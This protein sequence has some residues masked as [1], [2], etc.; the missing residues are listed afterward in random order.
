MQL[1]LCKDNAN[2]RKESLLFIF[3]VRLILCKNN[4][5]GRK[6]SLLLISRVHLILYKDTQHVAVL[7]DVTPT[8]QSIFYETNAG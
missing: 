7:Q 5:N 1:I 2:E 8:E 3:R 6:E 4:A